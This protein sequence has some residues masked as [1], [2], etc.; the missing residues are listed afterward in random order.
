[1]RLVTL[2]P[3]RHFLFLLVE[4]QN[5]AL[6]IDITASKVTFSKAFLKLLLILRGILSLVM[7]LVKKLKA[8]SF[9]YYFLFSENFIILK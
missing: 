9:C 6:I 1:M 3:L 8:Q 4:I 7:T 5:R 2:F